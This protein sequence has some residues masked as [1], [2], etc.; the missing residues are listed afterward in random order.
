MKNELIHKYAKAAS[1]RDFLKKGGL[2]LAATF[3]APTI[4]SC[5]N[6]NQSGKEK[7][8]AA[9]FN[10]VISLSSGINDEISRQSIER[11]K[12]MNAQ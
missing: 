6:S 3:A 4:L 2:G 5:A 11:V 1:R 10:R 9:Y 8:A 12:L 7:E